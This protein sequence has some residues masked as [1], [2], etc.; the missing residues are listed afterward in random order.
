MGAA[1]VGAAGVAAGTSGSGAA[2]V[3]AGQPSVAG[4]GGSAGAAGTVGSAGTAGVA[5]SGGTTSSPGTLMAQIAARAIP[6]GGE[7][8]VCV[9][10]ALENT[11]PVWVNEVRAK[12]S[13]GSHHLIVDR[14]PPSSSLQA[15]PQPCSPTMAG[16]STRLIIAQQAE[17]SV[18]LPSGVAF[19]LAARQPL[20][21]QLHYINL[22][23]A[24]Q[25]IIGTVELTL[26][27]TQGGAPIEAKSRFT[28]ATNINIP[29]RGMSTAKS[30]F[31]PGAGSSVRVFAVTSHTHRLGIKSTIERVADQD[32]PAVTPLHVSMDWAE[33][34]LTQFDP[35]LTFNG[36]DG[37]RLTCEYRND[38]DHTVTFGILAEQEMCFMWL[39]YYDQ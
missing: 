35:A 14:Q 1:G 19:S 21:L 22:K 23:D 4:T 9:V 7:E 28:G 33:P 26:V 39:Y 18:K 34:P 31:S 29:A 20:F 16:D 30:F 6:P 37:F 15:T 5:G 10:T 36:T 12:L 27:D 38:T 13:G 8:H 2:G 3:A 25:D 24:P 17:T 32:A 11:Q